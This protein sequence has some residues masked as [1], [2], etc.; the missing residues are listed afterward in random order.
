MSEERASEYSGKG[1][2]VERVAKQEN[3]YIIWWKKQT[4]TTC[5]FFCETIFSACGIL[6]V[7]TKKPLFSPPNIFGMGFTYLPRNK[8]GW[9]FL[10]SFGGISKNPHL[11]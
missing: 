6:W 7:E 1:F 9:L 11:L 10:L 5:H 3:P 4:K 2:E 8:Y